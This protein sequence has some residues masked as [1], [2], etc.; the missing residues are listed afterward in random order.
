MLST[1]QQGPV[2][3]GVQQGVPPSDGAGKDDRV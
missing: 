3:S 1:A 2:L